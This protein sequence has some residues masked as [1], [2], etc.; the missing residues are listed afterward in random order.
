MPDRRQALAELQKAT[1]DTAVGGQLNPEQAKA[2]MQEIQD[3]SSFGSQIR[4][5]QRTATKGTIE[6]MGSGSRLIRGAI[7]NADDGYRAGISTDEI[8]YDAGKLKLPFEVTEDFFRHNIEGQPVEPKIVGRMT[9]QFGNDLDDLN[10]NGD[11]SDV[12]GEAAFVALDDGL[13]VKAETGGH[14]HRVK[15]TE[16]KDGEGKKLEG[17]MASELFFAAKYAMPDKYVNSGRLRWM[18][19]PNRWTSWIESLIHRNTGV[20]D[21]ALTAKDLYPLGIP[22][23]IAASSTENPNPMPGVPF[24]PDDRILL[25]DPQNLVRVV[26]WDVRSKRVTGDTD[27]ELATRDKRGYIFF[28]EQDFVIEEEDAIVDLFELGAITA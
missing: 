3:S 14:T 22:P 12:S 4:Q 15:A 11:E 21:A 19:S 24:F 1:I 20:G 8:E 7:E 13:L 17:A 18:M 23:M 2:F 6:K 26:T 10:I 28:I 16:V 25:C 5:E 27:W 9:R